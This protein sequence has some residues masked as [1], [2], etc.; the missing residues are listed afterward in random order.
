F[1]V[2]ADGNT[3][4]IVDVCGAAVQPAVGIEV[5]DSAP[6]LGAG[7]K[8]SGRGKIDAAGAVTD[9]SVRIADRTSAGILDDFLER[10]PGA[11]DPDDPVGEVAKD[12]QRSLAGGRHGGRPASL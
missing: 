1:S 4:G 5:K 6:C 12:D 10:F 11:A 2:P 7:G 3:V 9:S 8:I